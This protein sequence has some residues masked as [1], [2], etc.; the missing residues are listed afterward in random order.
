MAVKILTS[1][2]CRQQFHAQP[3]SVLHSCKCHCTRRRDDISL[4]LCP[5]TFDKTRSCSTSWWI[6]FRRPVWH[7]TTLHRFMCTNP[8]AAPVHY[9][10]LLKCVES[11]IKQSQTATSQYYRG[12]TEEKIVPQSQLPSSL[13]ALYSSNFFSAF[14]SPFVRNAGV[15]GG[16]GFRAAEIQNIRRLQLSV[17]S[18][19]SSEYSTVLNLY[20]HV[21]DKPAST[22]LENHWAQY[23]SAPWGWK[24]KQLPFSFSR[25][26][27]F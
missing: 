16:G 3:S 1:S 19:H 6:V 22:R 20:W 21:R 12:K 24:L 18:L 8:A 13:L 26:A 23:S 7:L 4:R 5:M 14:A 17:Q 9:S 15:L 27:G 25:F 11:F 10:L 2:L